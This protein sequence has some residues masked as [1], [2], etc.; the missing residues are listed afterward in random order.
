MRIKPHIG[1]VLAEHECRHTPLQW[2]RR[3]G[4]ALVCNVCS[5]GGSNPFAGP[6]SFDIT[7][8]GL[9]PGSLQQLS[10]IPPGSAQAYFV[11]D[12]LGTTGNTGTV[13][14]TLTSSATPEPGAPPLIGAGTLLLTLSQ[15]A[16]ERGM[17]Y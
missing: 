5:N 6:I 14:A 3:L 8:S 1:L 13:G 17:I 7:A 2:V 15:F 12:I 11:A 16:V 9:T 4:L 10:T